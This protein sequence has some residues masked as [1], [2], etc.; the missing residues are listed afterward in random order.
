MWLR[1]ALPRDMPQLRSLI[2]GYDTKLFG[3]H[4]FQ[5]LEDIA[6]S[7]IA[8]LK[9]IHRSQAPAKPLIFLAHSLGGIVLKQALVL[10]AQDGNDEEQM[11]LA[12]VRGVVFFGVPHRGMEISHFRA[13]VANQPNED[14]I[15]R[16]LSPESDLLPILHENFSRIA[17]GMNQKVAFVYET[18][19]S[20]LTE[21]SVSPGLH[22]RL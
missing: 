12:S 5:D 17:S 14:L 16:A 10:L 3:S 7:F 9:Q 11:I 21:A 2:Y 18:M 22:E 13:M 4:S 15:S 19:Q 20:Q 1:D 8:S 6:R